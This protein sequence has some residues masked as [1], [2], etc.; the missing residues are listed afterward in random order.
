LINPGLTTAEIISRWNDHAWIH[1]PGGDTQLAAI[2]A[3]AHN[4]P[5]LLK[6]VH[7]DIPLVRTEHGGKTIFLRADADQR[8]QDQFAQRV[9]L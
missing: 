4:F 5:K 2:R 1:G 9:G 6:R 8:T 3:Y 7:E